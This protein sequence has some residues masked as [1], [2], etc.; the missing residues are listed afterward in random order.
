[1]S[2][3][4]WEDLIER[5]LA[6]AARPEEVEALERRLVEDPGAARALLAAA[7]RDVALRKALQARR[8]AA[9]A[10]R[11]APRRA[12]RKVAA[13]GVATGA[14]A[15]AVAI[16]L[17]L[18]TAPAPA[19]APVS[20]AA[21]LPEAPPPGEG[22]QPPPAPRLAVE[23]APA[24][25]RVEPAPREVPAPPPSTPPPAP[26]AASGAA[27]GV[28]PAPAPSTVA[29]VGEV[30]LARGEVLLLEEGS[31]TP[32]R[33][34]QA[35]RPGQGLRTGR[36]GAARIAF[37]DGSVLELEAHT[38]V[39]G[40]SEGTRRE[41]RLSSGAAAARVSP[42][43]AGHAFVLVTPHARVT[44]LGTEFRVSVRPAQTGVAVLEGRVQVSEP[45]GRGVTVLA[46]QF[47]VAEAGAPPAL[48]RA[49]S[50]VARLRGGV[51][52]AVY[53]DQNTAR[54]P[55]VERL[56]PGIELYLPENSP[57]LPPVGRDRNFA[58]V[59]EGWFLAEQEGEYLFLL[60]VDGQARLTI[61]GQD[62]VAEPRGVFHPI[63]R[64][65]LRRS[66]RPGWRAV[67]LEYSD[68]QGASRCVLRYV[69]PGTPAPAD[70]ESDEAGERIPP[71]LW[72]APQR[73]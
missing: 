66:L 38:V 67:K 42:Q 64:Y 14:A 36:E 22:T 20:R 27:P 72:A 29:A 65:A 56:E 8:A 48:W 33:A 32:T 41:V 60:S 73:R 71:S 5:Y 54:G 9:R 55:S 7:R 12:A 46:G 30:T 28:A 23:K 35:I 16:V 17:V 45:A 4:E 47:A 69:P 2:A 13:W 25:P 62:L 40:F 1:M 63:R 11:R 18:R 37:P 61:D 43:P 68:D 52:R 31:S 50:G 26:P 59:W 53:Y 44:V 57:D 19:P 6:G 39:E 15:A 58:A 24:T 34:G 70:L 51:L 21:P 49:P 3:A 10:V